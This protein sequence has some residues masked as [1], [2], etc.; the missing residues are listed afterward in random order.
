MQLCDQLV[1]KDG[2]RKGEGEEGGV[3]EGEKKEKGL[4]PGGRGEG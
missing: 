1:S 2:P 4:A 3:V